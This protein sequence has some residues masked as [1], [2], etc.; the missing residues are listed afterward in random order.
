M[1]L[2]FIPT[3]A[4]EVP[5]LGCHL[6]GSLVLHLGYQALDGLGGQEGSNGV[7][8]V[9][10]SR[11]QQSRLQKQHESPLEWISTKSNWTKQTFCKA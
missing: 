1:L 9:H 7:A 2:V 10:L 5:C 11:R 6:L 8:L 4:A 3:L